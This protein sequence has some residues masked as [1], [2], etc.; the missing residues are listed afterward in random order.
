MEVDKEMNHFY[1]V[2]QAFRL[3]RSTDGAFI[4]RRN[5]GGYPESESMSVHSPEGGTMA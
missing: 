5:S 4:I 3:C 2:P 1:C